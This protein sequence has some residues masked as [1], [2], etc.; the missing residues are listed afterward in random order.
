MHR[1]PDA[2]RVGG[3]LKK[4]YREKDPYGTQTGGVVAAPIQRHVKKPPKTGKAV[5]RVNAQ[6]SGTSSVVPK[7]GV[8]S[9][10]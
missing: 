2:G 10:M 8:I 3:Y 1:N 7:G 5:G 6:N 9:A 4:G